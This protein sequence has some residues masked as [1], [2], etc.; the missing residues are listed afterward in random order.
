LIAPQGRRGVGKF[1]ITNESGQEAVVK[2]AAR[3]APDTP[4]RL[5]YI[6]PGAETAITGI[7]TGVYIVSFSLGPITGKPRKFGAATG[8]FQFI[9]VDAVT[10]VQSDEYRLVIKP[11]S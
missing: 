7:G 8:P 5:V 3:D 1:R 10:G 6:A 11:Q 2:V 9:E 4:L